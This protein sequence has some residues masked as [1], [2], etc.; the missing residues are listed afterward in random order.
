MD[1]GNHRCIWLKHQ[2]LVYI[3]VLCPAHESINNYKWRRQTKCILMGLSVPRIAKSHA[4]F[5]SLLRAVGSAIELFHHIHAFEEETQSDGMA[6]ESC[7]SFLTC[8]LC[9]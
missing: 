6:S 4:Y 9:S 7:I 2:K 5:L 3:Y 1:R 8:K